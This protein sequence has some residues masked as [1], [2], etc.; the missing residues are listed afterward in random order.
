MEKQAL[1]SC[2]LFAAQGIIALVEEERRSKE[3]RP[4]AEPWQYAFDR[5]VSWYTMIL[6]IVMM[7]VF[8]FVIT[9]VVRVSL[10]A[11]IASSTSQQRL[12]DVAHDQLQ[13]V[14]EFVVDR[15]FIYVFA[16]WVPVLL[17][18]SALFYG[19]YNMPKESVPAAYHAAHAYA[20]NAF[21][22]VFAFTWC[23][24]ARYF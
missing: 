14:M 22:L 23:V 5:L 6:R 19:F 9:L 17:W 16:V 13:Y 11:L 4:A 21:A 2:G 10:M 3:I 24:S 18:V 1:V 12:K 8:I 7:M 15:H 20:L